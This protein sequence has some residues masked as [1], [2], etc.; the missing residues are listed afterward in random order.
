[1]EVKAGHLQGHGQVHQEC[2]HLLYSS[3]HSLRK[4][5][6]SWVPLLSLSWNNKSDLVSRAELVLSEA[7][8]PYLI[9]L[10]WA[11]QILQV[12][13]YL[14]SPFSALAP[15]GKVVIISQ[16]YRLLFESFFFSSSP[17]LIERRECLTQLISFSY[18]KA[19]GET[20]RL[21]LRTAFVLKNFS[22]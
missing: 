12:A 3:K 1:M 15:S 6:G 10:T 2:A 16:G 14:K 13:H 19:I 17:H 20:G 7:N 22:V 11:E 18:A 8:A 5:S 9:T 21:M 4:V